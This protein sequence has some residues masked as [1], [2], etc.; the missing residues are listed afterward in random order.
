MSNSSSILNYEHEDYFQISPSIKT[1]QKA[2]KP[3]GITQLFRSKEYK[4]INAFIATTNLRPLTNSDNGSE[5]SYSYTSSNYFTASQSNSIDNSS[6]D[7]QNYVDMIHDSKYNTPHP[8][9]DPNTLSRTSSSNL[10]DNQSEY[11]VILDDGTRQKRTVSLSTLQPISSQ[12]L[13]GTISSRKLN[14]ER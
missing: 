14:S 11:E 1:Q 13:S 4:P 7:F 9:T 12:Q 8:F 5:A 6:I 3:S 2:N 10:Y